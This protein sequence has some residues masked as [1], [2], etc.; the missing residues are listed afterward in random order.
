MRTQLLLNGGY[1]IM[2]FTQSQSLLFDLIERTVMLL[3]LKVVEG[4]LLELEDLQLIEQF[5]LGEVLTSG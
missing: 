5:L 3:Q 2:Q 1:A 4:P